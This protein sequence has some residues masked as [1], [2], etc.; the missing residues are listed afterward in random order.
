MAACARTRRGRGGER[1]S[2]RAG[3]AAPRARPRCGRLVGGP[4]ED[5]PRHGRS[6]PGGPRREDLLTRPL[7]AFVGRVGQPGVLGQVPG[8]AEGPVGSRRLGFGR[9]A[10]GRQQ[11]ERTVGQGAGTAGQRGQ[12]GGERPLGRRLERG[13]VAVPPPAVLAPDGVHDEL[14]LVVDRAEIGPG[15]QCLGR[16]HG[17]D[18]VVEAAAGVHDGQRLV[19]ERVEEVRRVGQRLAD[20][21]GA[22]DREPV[23]GQEEL[24]VEREHAAQGVRPL[25]RVALHLLGV[26]GVGRGPDEEVTAA[27]DAGVGLPGDGVVVGLALLVPQGEVDAAHRH[28]ERVV[29]GPVGVAVLGRP[30]EVGEAE[31]AAVDDRVVARGEDVAVE[32]GGQRVMRDDLRGWPSPPRR[33]PPPTPARRRRGRCARGSRRRC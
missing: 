22:D 20:P 3:A 12:L 5:P 23:S 16:A 13:R 33:P 25:A 1:I 24:G 18:G 29:V 9:V 2:A 11:L 7:D 28:V 6:R 4:G 21:V 30:V 31:L 27:Q 32:A 10:R 17:V 26:A 8:E 14:R 19:D 15:L